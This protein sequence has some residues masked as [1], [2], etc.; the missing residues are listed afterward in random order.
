VLP[1]NLIRPLPRVGAR[2]DV[3]F[4]DPAL[5]TSM[6]RRRRDE[7]DEDSATFWCEE[8]KVYTEGRCLALNMYTRR[9]QNIQV[10]NRVITTLT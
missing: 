3:G 7:K 2:G 5:P 8:E 6:A 9:S 10:T 1:K 4:G